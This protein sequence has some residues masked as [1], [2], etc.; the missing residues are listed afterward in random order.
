MENSQFILLPMVVLFLYNFINRHD[1]NK[2]DYYKALFIGFVIYA[3]LSVMSGLDAG[4]GRGVV[5]KYFTEKE[6]AYAIA[7][8]DEYSDKAAYHLDL[9]CL[10]IYKIPDME[11]KE[12]AKIAISAG[13]IV[14]GSGGNA[15]AWVQG[16]YAALIATGVYV[17]DKHWDIIAENLC[18]ARYYYEMEAWMDECIIQ[19]SLDEDLK[20]IRWPFD[21]KKD[22]LDYYVC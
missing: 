13:V 18:W 15:A 9:A 17:I 4:E 6:E 1:N 21:F 11:M 16:L 5:R 14:V 2:E 10:Q 22:G 19:N 3:L 8:R 7:K 12:A 20:Q